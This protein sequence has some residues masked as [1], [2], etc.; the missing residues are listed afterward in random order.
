MPERQFERESLDFGSFE[1]SNDLRIVAASVFNVRTGKY[2]MLG[3][4]NEEAVE[5]TLE[6][7]E[8]VFWSR[9][10]NGL[11]LKGETSNNKLIVVGQA[12]DCDGDT[13]KYYV[14]PLGPVCHTGA[15]SCFDVNASGGGQT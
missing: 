3:Y 11:W 10:R 14:E 7:G 9:S 4:Q 1:R 13:I 12:I 5:R 15:E 2:L 8:M 6:R